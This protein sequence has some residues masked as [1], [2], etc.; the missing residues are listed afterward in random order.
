MLF[1]LCTNIIR[2]IVVNVG[3]N[4]HNCLLFVAFVG[5][6]VAVSN[7]SKEKKCNHNFII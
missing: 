3:E 7:Y 2:I 5:F 1:N 4:G 6:P